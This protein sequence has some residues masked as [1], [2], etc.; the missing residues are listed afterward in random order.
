[1]RN[2]ALPAEKVDHIIPLFYRYRFL[3]CYIKLQIYVELFA[4]LSIQF[5]D[6]SWK[7]TAHEMRIYV[8]VSR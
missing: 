2:F 8:A 7:L 6:V 5:S 4:I 1:M 3:F